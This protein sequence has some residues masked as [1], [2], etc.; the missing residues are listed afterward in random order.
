MGSNG[1]KKEF[2]TEMEG[3]RRETKSLINEIKMKFPW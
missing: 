2:L 1:N 3:N